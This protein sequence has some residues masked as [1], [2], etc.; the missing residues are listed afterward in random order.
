MS[1]IWTVWRVVVPV[2]KR[3]IEGRAHRRRQKERERRDRA[4]REKSATPLADEIA[5]GVRKFGRFPKE[6][7]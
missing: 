6:W 2:E 4:P 5:R 7:I 1:G 3:E